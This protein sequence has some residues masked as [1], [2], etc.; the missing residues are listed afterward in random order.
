MTIRYASRALDLI[1]KYLDKDLCDC[2][3]IA[4][5]RGRKVPLITR[6][7]IIWPIAN[8]HAGYLG[9]IAC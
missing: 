7:T 9:I 1:A 6:D 8:D 5:A 2:F 4:S 3:V